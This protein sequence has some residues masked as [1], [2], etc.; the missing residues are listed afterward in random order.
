MS[1]GLWL[2]CDR[3]MVIIL[4]GKMPLVS[5]SLVYKLLQYYLLATAISVTVSNHYVIVCPICLHQVKLLAI[6]NASPYQ[7]WLQR[8]QSFS[9]TAILGLTLVTNIEMLNH[10]HC[11][12]TLNRNITHTL[13]TQFYCNCQK[14][15][16]HTH[17]HT[18]THT[19]I[20][21]SLYSNTQTL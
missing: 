4:H 10:G 20:H 8:H 13:T 14:T 11:Q 1:L 16:T 5:C 9:G 3:T 2:N 17:T 15:H 18:L 6:F 12:K 19:I 7:I 21:Y